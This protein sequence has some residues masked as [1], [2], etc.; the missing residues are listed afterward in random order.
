MTGVLKKCAQSE[1]NRR[2]CMHMMTNIDDL[3]DQES[4]DDD[5]RFMDEFL[6]SIP[7]GDYLDH[8][9]TFQNDVDDHEEN[10]DRDL[11]PRGRSYGAPENTLSIPAY[12]IIDCIQT[13][14]S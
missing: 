13:K 12:S 1:M 14:H 2:R 9:E 11:G 6:E 4:T 10:M 8:T 5:K 3:S 7:T